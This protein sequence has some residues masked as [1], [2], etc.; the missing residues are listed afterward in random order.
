MH[1]LRLPTGRDR[2]SDCKRSLTGVRKEGTKTTPS[3]M[4]TCTRSL[5]TSFTC[6]PRCQRSTAVA[7]YVRRRAYAD[8]APLVPD[9]GTAFTA[10]GTAST[11]CEPGAFA[12]TMDRKYRAF[13]HEHEIPL[14]WPADDHHVALKPARS[15]VLDNELTEE[16]AGTWVGIWTDAAPGLGFG[17]TRG[18]GGGRACACSS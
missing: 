3:Y 5:T 11:V 17:R 1:M 16:Y 15:R 4:R 9:F 8:C 12:Q 2:K 13:C 14:G 7:G 6:L 10:F 18:E